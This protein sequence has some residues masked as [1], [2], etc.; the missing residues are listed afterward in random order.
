ML[1]NAIAKTTL[2]DNLNDIRIS[3]ITLFLERLIER[4]VHGGGINQYRIKNKLTDTYIT[5]LADFI[6]AI[7]ETE[8]TY[9]FNYSGD[10]AEADRLRSLIIIPNNFIIELDSHTDE[11]DL[12]FSRYGKSV[13]RIM[14]LLNYMNDGDT[15]L[16]LKVFDIRLF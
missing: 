11:D 7:D 12:Y 9:D 8:L 10:K 13:N 15:G 14:F 6:L 4:K 2:V 5:S 1:T 16:P 3:A